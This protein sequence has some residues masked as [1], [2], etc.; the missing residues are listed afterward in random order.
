[1]AKHTNDFKRFIVE[2]RLLHKKGYTQIE[3]EHGVL[4]GTTYTWVK[5]HEEGILFIDKRTIKDRQEKEKKE[6]E[7]LKKSFALLKEIRSKQQE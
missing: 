7:F 3:R 5:K 1:M 4:R 6:H 2:E